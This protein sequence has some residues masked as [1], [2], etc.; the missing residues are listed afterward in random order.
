MTTY[1]PK[2]EEQLVEESLLQEGT[3]DFEVID[4][5]DRPSKKGN[6]MI[7]LKLA[8]FAG[9]G[10]Q[11]HIFDYI[12]FGTNFGERKFRHAAEACGLMDIYNSGK[13]TDQD[14]QGASGKLILK[15][16]EGT[17]EFPAK[18]VVAEYLPHEGEASKP[19]RPAKEIL[20]DD[21]PF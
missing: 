14:F 9:D 10:S 1:T 3:Y 8:V 18:N 15:K 7:T 13:M 2:S 21:L 12:A 17:V 5:D 19:A 20:N 4:T 6:E 11:R 16:Q